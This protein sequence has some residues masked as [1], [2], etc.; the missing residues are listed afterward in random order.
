MATPRARRRSNELGI[1]WHQ[2]Q[3]TGRNGRIRERDV[4]SHV[5]AVKE[6]QHSQSAASGVA[7]RAQSLVAPS[8]SG[9]FE[10]ASKIRRTIAQ[11]MLAGVTQTAPVTLT[12]KVDA[13]GIVRLREELKA[14]SAEAIVPSYNDMLVKLAAIVLREYPQLNACWHHDG[15]WTYDEVHAG[16]AVETPAG[17]LAPVVRDVDKMSLNE[18]AVCSRSLAEQARSGKLTQDQLEGGTFTITNLGSFGVDFFTP[19]INLPQAAILG[20]G[21]IRQEPVVRDDQL[22]IGHTL[23]LSLTF[24]HRVIDGAPAAAW[25]QRFCEL[26][27]DCRERLSC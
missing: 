27:T 13:S 11:R 5:A 23:S 3:G 6:R 21:R 14:G 9:R 4:I 17:L 19:I 24:D 2:V 10:S 7:A 26:I 8:T 20:V 25:L 15:I 12:T 1:D 22:A 18:I 16:V